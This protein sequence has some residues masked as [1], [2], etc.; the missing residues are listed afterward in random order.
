MS[1]D[2]TAAR[3]EVLRVLFE[4]CLEKLAGSMRRVP[5]CFL[6]YAHG[7]AAEAERLE[8]LAGDL[9]TAGVRVDFDR[10][11]PEDADIPRRSERVRTADA[12]I[13]AGSV[14][15]REKWEREEGWV[16]VE[17][18]QIS[19]RL[20]SQPRT[21]IPITLI[22]NATA[23]L[24]PF[25]DGIAATDF[26]P[27][28][29]YFFSFLELLQR[30]YRDPD[31][32]D[33]VKIARGR[34]KEIRIAVFNRDTQYSTEIE[35]IARAIAE[36]R[37]EE[38][39]RLR[40]EIRRTAAVRLR[41]GSDGSF[42]RA[43]F[44]SGP[45]APE[46]AEAA[47]CD[48]HALVEFGTDADEIIPALERALASG[49]NVNGWD[50]EHRRR[51]LLYIAVERATDEEEGVALSLK[52][53]DFLLDV[54]GISVDRQSRYG[55]TPLHKA[56]NVG[57]LEVAQTL[58]RAGAN[59]RA[60]TSMRASTVYEA[61][62]SSGV[63]AGDIVQLMQQEGADIDVRSSD[64]FSPLMVAI[65]RRNYDV[66]E[67]LMQRTGHINARDKT[68]ETAFYK[69]VRIGNYDLVAELLKAK[70][71]PSIHRYADAPKI[72]GLFRAAQE[73]D[74]ETVVAWIR[75]GESIN[76]RYG[77]YGRTALHQAAENGRFGIVKLL[78]DNGADVFARN[79]HGRTP[80]DLTPPRFTR[81]VDFLRVEEKLRMRGRKCPA[82]Y[83][84]N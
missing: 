73:G 29:D 4:G 31:L 26:G 32:I 49:F 64:S 30:I 51:T 52:L 76:T 53:L 38:A 79:N 48:L 13:V 56:A 19:A 60:L 28:S 34:L 24:P 21:V 16:S 54:P 39:Q 65:W 10:L 11:T 42:G 63:D 62:F 8:R 12:V 83:Y 84:E 67:F 9:A 61:A 75:N 17:L 2:L 69:A 43:G 22:G 78:V 50:D 33:D 14:G 44:A 82:P 71:D 80:R 57:V 35:A 18:R 3:D 6:C 47:T 77:P 68:G 5:T 46:G 74:Y 81:V 66:A 70:A 37:D 58:L 15:L 1:Q 20:G 55:Y 23:S 72:G 25:L 41:L 59:A 45:A 40:D 36:K 7:N 27:A